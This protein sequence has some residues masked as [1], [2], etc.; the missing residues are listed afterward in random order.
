MAYDEVNN[1]EMNQIANQILEAYHD[2][3]LISIG[4]PI[5]EVRNEL[6]EELHFRLIHD[7]NS[8]WYL[9]LTDSYN[10][11]FSCDSGWYT[12]CVTLR[13]PVKELFVRNELN[14][15]MDARLVYVYTSGNH[16]LYIFEH[17]TSEFT[18]IKPNTVE[19][20]QKDL[21]AI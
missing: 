13:E 5:F 1:K 2:G 15:T 16:F 8:I 20:I 6:N 9:T 12:Q 17:N 11:T 21:S 19:K 14:K 10:G 4:D 3:S 7:E 18:P